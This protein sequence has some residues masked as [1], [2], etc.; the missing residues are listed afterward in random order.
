[1]GSKLGVTFYAVE[2]RDLWQLLHK[3][4]DDEFHL[5]CFDGH[6]ISFKAWPLNGGSLAVNEL[7]KKEVMEYSI[8]FKYCWGWYLGFCHLTSISDNKRKPWGLTQAGKELRTCNIVSVLILFCRQKLRQLDLERSNCT[9]YPYDWTRI[10]E[11][12]AERVHCPNL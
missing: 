4:I 8:L 10:W 3:F 6:E 1:M 5:L 12:L 9:K 11:C 2:R 7:S